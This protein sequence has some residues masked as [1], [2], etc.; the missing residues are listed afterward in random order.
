MVVRPSHAVPV[1]D[2]RL[3]D[4]ELAP[5]PLNILKR[6][7][8]SKSAHSAC[9][10]F[11]PSLKP[12]TLA[13]SRRSSNSRH[14][15]IFGLHHEKSVKTIISTSEADSSL[16]VR[17]QRR[18]TS[19]SSHATST[20]MSFNPSAEQ[21][22]RKP[23]TDYGSNLTLDPTSG[24]KL[25]SGIGKGSWQLMPT[26]A[27]R[28]YSAGALH[29]GPLSNITNQ[30]VSTNYEA[31]GA[32][33]RQRAVTASALPSFSNGSDDSN[34]GPLR[35]RESLRSR[36]MSRMMGGFPN[37]FQAPHEKTIDEDRFTIT[38]PA[39]KAYSRRSS[40]I[41]DRLSDSSTRAKPC[42]GTD[43]SD[44]LAAFPAPPGGPFTP[45]TSA[46]TSFESS[47]IPSKRFRELSRPHS[48][49]LL[50]AELTFTP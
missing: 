2:A 18:K 6:I 29:H 48:I 43:L 32:T 16:N 24:P 3:E 13:S 47:R 31:S 14:S 34:P 27:A 40:E 9:D 22:T 41:V 15:S 38:P 50:R 35:H 30:S 4:L 44:A 42:V 21:A 39:S 25:P 36:M 1:N 45:R 28:S 23:A 20:E 11:T 17:K 10:L 46:E 7:V 49:G 5:K 12:N 8:S 37:R 26:T 33:Q 19:I